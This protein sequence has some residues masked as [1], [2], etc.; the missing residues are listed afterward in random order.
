MDN[1]MREGIAHGGPRD[2]VKLSAGVGWDGR[3]KKPGLYGTD[4]SQI[5]RGTYY[6]RYAWSG[7]LKAW[8]WVPD[9]DSRL[10]D[11]R[12]REFEQ[13]NNK[14]PRASL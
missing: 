14:Y 12:I 3:I 2:K 13:E 6:G 11:L 9:V 5:S 8:L 10:T 7:V 4:N 1:P